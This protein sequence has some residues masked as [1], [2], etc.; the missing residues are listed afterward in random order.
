MVQENAK[1]LENEIFSCDP[2]LLYY[3]YLQD[4]EKDDGWGCAYRSLQTIF[5]WFKLQNLTSKNVIFLIEGS[6]Y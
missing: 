5:S 3:H 4:K 6:F 2:H 1:E